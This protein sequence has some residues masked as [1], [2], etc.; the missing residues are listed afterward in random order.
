MAKCHNK[1]HKYLFCSSYV[2]RRLCIYIP[3][4]LDFRIWRIDS[5]MLDKRIKFH[6]SQRLDMC[7]FSTCVVVTNSDKIW[8]VMW[9]YNPFDSVE[10]NLKVNCLKFAM[11]IISQD[12]S[13]CRPMFNLIPFKP[14]QI[15]YTVFK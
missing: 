2:N 3:I 13:L 14:S 1:F 6:A 11:Y 12:Y 9:K 5:V 10:V 15:I 7:L 4:Y 8:H